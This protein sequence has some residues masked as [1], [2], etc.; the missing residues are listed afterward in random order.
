MADTA[1]YKRWIHEYHWNQPSPWPTECGRCPK[2]LSISTS[3]SL[4]SEAEVDWLAMFND[5]SVQKYHTDHPLSHFGSKALNLRHRIGLYCWM[6]MGGQC[7]E[8]RVFGRR[9][10]QDDRWVSDRSEWAQSRFI[11]IDLLRFQP[12]NVLVRRVAFRQFVESRSVQIVLFQL[13]QQF[14]GNYLVPEI[15]RVV[16]CKRGIVHIQFPEMRHRLQIECLHTPLCRR[17]SAGI[18]NGSDWWSAETTWNVLTCWVRWCHG[19]HWVDNK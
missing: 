18:R 6:M 17:Q 10:F 9:H 11:P 14:P 3:Q 8:N 12:F 16:R 15:H 5:C 13:Q 2:Y 7:L 1:K 19:A 4:F